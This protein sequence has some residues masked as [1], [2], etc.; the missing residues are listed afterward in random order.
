MAKRQYVTDLRVGE[1]LEISD[2]PVTLTVQAKSG[3]LA[4]LKFEHDGE[5]SFRRLENR[6]LPSQFARHGLKVA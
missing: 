3:Q 2:G 5:V 1:S 6:A 4:R